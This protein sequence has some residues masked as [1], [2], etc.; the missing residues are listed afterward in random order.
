MK[1]IG[2]GALKGCSGISDIVIPE[3]VTTIGRDAFQG[4]SGISEIV[5]P[6]SVTSIGNYAFLGC[7]ALKSFTVKSKQITFGENLFYY[8]SV[9]SGYSGS[10]ECVNLNCEEVPAKMF[11]GI[12]TITEVV[13]GESVKSVGENAFHEYG[14]VKNLS[15]L[16]TNTIINC[17]FGR[18]LEKV[19]YNSEIIPDGLFSYNKN[20]KEVVLGE[21]VKSIDLG[22]FNDC[23]S[24]TEITLPEGLE[25]IGRAAFSG[26][27]FTSLTIPA[28]VSYIGEYAFDCPN[29]TSLISY[30]VDPFKTDGS[31]LA[32]SNLWDK[33]TLYVPAGSSEKYRTTGAWWNFHNIVEM[34]VNDIQVA[35]AFSIKADKIYN[36]RGQ[37]L[38]AP[39][40]G[41]NI[42][43][44]KKVVVK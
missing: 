39:Q 25:S 44:G 3:S 20:L 35:N 32:G 6:E 26:A 22:A 10:L 30:I 41:I 13:L 36:L 12:N 5:I 28:N 9:M 34:P 29:M 31:Y 8:Y 17:K 40:K 33:V 16:G 18:N 2:E 1:T 37:R 19:I 23:I 4:C 21:S 15:V 42:I 24:L 38:S 14:N 7:S 27:G 11:D 43:G